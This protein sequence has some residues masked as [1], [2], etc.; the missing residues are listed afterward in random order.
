MD[1]KKSALGQMSI[2]LRMLIE[3]SHTELATAK[4]NLFVARKGELP[5]SL[6][7]I[8]SSPNDGRT[9]ATAC[10]GQALSQSQN[11]LLIDSCIAK[12]RL[13]E[14]FNLPRAPGLTEFIEDQARLETIVNST[15]IPR[16]Q[17]LT[18][19]RSMANPSVSFN[20][21]RIKELLHQAREGWDCIICDT[22]P[23]LGPSD[24]SFLAQYFE[25]A[26]LVVDSN[27]TRWEIAQIVAERFT[28]ARGQLIG[29][30]MNRRQY[31]I[32]RWFYRFL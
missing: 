32:P 10:L 19:G 9:V 28:A 26:L 5:R 8:S 30:I 17:V 1:N 6:L 15:E 7:I 22:P 16:L 25:N 3:K 2:E 24:T 20:G 4:G 14:L 21:E 11:V 23:Y 29:V 31:Y 12:P 27:R 18:A 13:H